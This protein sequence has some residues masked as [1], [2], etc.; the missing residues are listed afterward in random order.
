[1]EEKPLIIRQKLEKLGY[2]KEEDYFYHLNRRL[3]EQRRKQL[4]VGRRRQQADQEKNSHWMKCPKCGSSLKDSN[5]LGIYVEQ[6]PDCGGVFMDQGEIETLL[7]A[8]RS[9]T[10]LNRLKRLFQPKEDFPT[11]F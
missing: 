7:E 6:C 11:F 1:M 10:F 5:I 2:S 3:I 8:K 9:R 4:D